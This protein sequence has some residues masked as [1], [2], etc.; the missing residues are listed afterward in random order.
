MPVRSSF[1]ASYQ[2]TKKRTQQKVREFLDRRPHRSFQRTRR[3]D[4]SRSLQLPGYVSFTLQVN[5][6]VWRL[7]KTFLL[8]AAVYILLTVVLVGLGSQQAY[9]SLAETLR[10]TGA[11]VFEGN[12]G[13]IGQA[14][15]LF[16]SL[17]SSGLTGTLT[18]A[19][20]I[21]AGLL[22]LLTWLTTVWILRHSLAGH[23]V[24]LR[25]ALYNAGS[26]IVST[27]LVGLVL[28]VQLLPLAIAIIG[29]AAA[30]ASGLLDGGIEAMLF[31]LTAGLLAVLSLYW[32]TSTF[33]ALVIVTLPG[34]YPLRALRSAGDIV[35]GRRLRILLRIVW[36][37]AAVVVAW[38]LILIPFILLDGGLKQLWPAIEPVPIIPT[39]LLALGTLSIIWTASYIYLLYR[40]VVEDDAQPA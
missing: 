37:T 40:K 26:P 28:A 7:R 34:M 36:M 39:V 8:L 21:Y 13:Q 33:V 1:R 35:V 17:A 32:I 31:W 10:E 38:A 23:T 20:Q 24:K 27:F 29:Y 12:W 25:D 3:R 6:K 22:V 2:K 14:G 16:A 4:Y 9:S 5:K 30:S 19:Q 15:L 18:E 11:E